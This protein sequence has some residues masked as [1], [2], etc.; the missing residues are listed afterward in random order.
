MIDKY[1]VI[2]IG[3]GVNGFSAAIRLQQQGLRTI[4]FEHSR[5]PGGSTKT[6]EATLPG[7]KHDIGSS[8]F[9][10]GF[11]S[12]FLSTLPLMDFGLEWV[13]PEIP[14]SQPFEDGSALACYRNVERTAN[15]LGQDKEAYLKLFGP[16]IKNWERL[17]QDLLGPLTW[18]RHPWEF[19]KFGLK[20][21]PSA[22][23][24]GNHYFKTDRSKAF[25]YGSAAHSTLPLNSLVSS[26]FGLVLTIL[27][28]KFGW[29]FPKGGAGNFTKALVEYYRSLGGEIVLNHT[30][31][32]LD[33]L[34]G[35]TAY[36]FDLT[37]KQLLGI[38]GTQLS[39]LYK[40]R[41]G[42]LQIWR[43]CVQD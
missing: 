27:A 11:A 7:F 40:K 25:F 16:A 9:P 42:K 5:S 23:M 43:R 39:W 29:P 22:V 33:K 24:V 41:L 6:E 13:F 1:D 4:I 10:L 12:P 38:K 21:L 17:D 36:M 37:P 32:D 26:S 34:P 8:I 20:A 30:V 28:H 14:F 2:I 19:V 18:P 3:S 15:Q 31:S 35:A